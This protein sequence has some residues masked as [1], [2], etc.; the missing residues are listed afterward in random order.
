M[1]IPHLK[2]ILPGEWWKINQSMWQSS[3]LGFSILRETLGA[4]SNKQY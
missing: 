4:F 3:M 1:I 2:A